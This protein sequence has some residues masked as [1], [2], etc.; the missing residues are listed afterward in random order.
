MPKG[1]KDRRMSGS[2]PSHTSAPPAGTD[3]ERLARLRAKKRQAAGFIMGLSPRRAPVPVKFSEPRDVETASPA[4]PKTD[5]ARL[6][7]LRAKR[8]LED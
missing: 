8:R 2:H 4:R 3:S 5:K 7:A 6:G 1:S